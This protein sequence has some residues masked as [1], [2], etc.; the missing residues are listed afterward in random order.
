MGC[1]SGSRDYGH[2]VL[3]RGFCGPG[4]EIEIKI[5]EVSGEVD[6]AVDVVKKKR[7]CAA[8]PDVP[9]GTAVVG[10]RPECVKI[11]HTDGR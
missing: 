9:M 1:F 5:K 6:E 2:F 8:V 10:L 7:Q 3:S 4:N 11:D